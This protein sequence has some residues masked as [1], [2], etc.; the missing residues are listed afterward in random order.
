MNYS[1]QREDSYLH[2]INLILSFKF[3]T[4]QHNSILLIEYNHSVYCNSYISDGSFKKLLGHHWWNF[5]RTDGSSQILACSNKILLPRPHWSKTCVD[6]PFVAN[7]CVLEEKCSNVDVISLPFL[8]SCQGWIFQPQQWR[9]ASSPFKY[10]GN[11][12]TPEFQNTIKEL[13][14]HFSTGPVFT[15][16]EHI[17]LNTWQF[18]DGEI[19]EQR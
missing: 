18:R 5:S 16:K 12:E 8:Q 11:Q 14:P 15:N 9:V 7:I 13:S 19:P 4:G 1:L 6:W 17:E 2:Q 10:F 3:S